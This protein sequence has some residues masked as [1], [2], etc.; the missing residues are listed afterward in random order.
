MHGY[1][2]RSRAGVMLLFALAWM[3]GEGALPAPAQYYTPRRHRRFVGTTGPRRTIAG[4]LASVDLASEV[5]V[6]RA[7]SGENLRLL[8][9]DQTHVSI[10]GSRASLRDL[11]SGASVSV[12]YFQ[13]SGVWVADQVSASNPRGASRGDAALGYNGRGIPYSGRGV[14]YAG[15][16]VPPSGGRPGALAS[17]PASPYTS[18]SGRS[19]SR[20]QEAIP[21]PGPRT[22]AGGWSG[23]SYETG[24][25]TTRSQP[26]P[27]R[28]R[29]VRPPDDS[30]PGRRV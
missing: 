22:T 4:V 1:G 9:D 15:R 21:P 12:T 26:P 8:V 5:L 18:A 19:Q 25:S 28:H 20:R 30:P 16:S 3:V 10:G 6:V 13:Y 29:P 14:P 24:N 11:R 23:K 17:A 27:R 7:R 2:R